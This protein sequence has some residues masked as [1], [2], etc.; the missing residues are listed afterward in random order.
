V[1]QVPGDPWRLTFAGPDRTPNTSTRRT[2]RLHTRT[3]NPKPTTNQEKQFT[4]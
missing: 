1:S 4:Q 3:L 2:R